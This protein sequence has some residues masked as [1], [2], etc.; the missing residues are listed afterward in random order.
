MRDADGG[1]CGMQTAGRA[2]FAQHT[3]SGTEHVAAAAT[4]ASS[5]GRSAEERGYGPQT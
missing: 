4:P 5:E 3:C 2:G 1:Q